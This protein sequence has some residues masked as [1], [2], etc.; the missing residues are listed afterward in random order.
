MNQALID[1]CAKASYDR[2]LKRFSPRIEWED[3]PSEVRAACIDQA[4]TILVASEKFLDADDSACYTLPN[5]ECIGIACMHDPAPRFV[6]IYN[7]RGVW[8]KVDRRDAIILDHS[9]TQFP[10]VHV[11]GA[12]HLEPRE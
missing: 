8:V 3:A 7:P 9:E 6:Q 11:V 2:F 10:D 4:L 1:H 5:G 12:F